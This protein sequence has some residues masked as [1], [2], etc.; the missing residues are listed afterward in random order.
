MTLGTGAARRLAAVADRIVDPRVGIVHGLECLRN[1]AGAPGFFHA[2]A[3]L[4]NLAALGW[5]VSR[6]RMDGA[7]ARREDAALKAIVEALRFYCA[8]FVRPDDL[9]LYPRRDAPFA[10]VDPRELALHG[11]EQRAWVDLPWQPFTDEAPVRWA[12]AVAADSGEPCHVPAAA[13]YFAYEVPAGGSEVAVVP[14]TPIGL[15]AAGSRVEAE[16][17]A[18]CSAVLH[19]ALAITWYARL[20]R[21][22]IRVETLSDANYAL[23]ERFESTGVSLTM[24]DL[25]LDLGVPTVLAVARNPVP[26]APAL[27]FAGGA[28]LGPEDAV[29]AALEELALVLRYGHQVSLYGRPLAAPLEPREVVDQ[30]GH[31]RFWC[32][33]AHAGLAE[34]VFASRE[35]IEFDE[36]P[37]LSDRGLE[38]GRRAL[39]E[40]LAA[41]GLRALICELTTRDVRELG[42][43]VVRA[44]VPGLQPLVVG[45]PTRVLGGGRLRELP[46]RFGAQTVN[47][48][49]APPHPFLIRGVVP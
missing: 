39:L 34:F 48:M 22:H 1:E 46:G 29:R 20:A 47:L 7:A 6:A 32:D 24:L 21:P 45:H 36:L 18:I 42:A 15:A 19:D 41:A 38:A 2:S 17:A 14:N 30:V 10:C 35:R 11:P 49:A 9:P 27:A 33:H 37:D 28:A 8:A 26:G 40:R 4:C 44:I 31:L 13:V 3:Q 25:G 43:T 12:P 23:V 16:V 5:P